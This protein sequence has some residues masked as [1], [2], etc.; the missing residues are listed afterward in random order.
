MTN[1][2]RD[3]DPSFNKLFERLETHSKQ[4]D[5][6][7]EI[8]KGNQS[9]L[10]TLVLNQ[11]RMDK[12]LDDHIDEENATLSVVSN[13]LRDLKGF[14]TILRYIGVVGKWTGIVAGVTGVVWAWDHL[15]QFM[16][17]VH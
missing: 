9:T 2:R 6:H 10:D 8:I 4:L 14:D 1:E 12:K 3:Y 15:V 5:S 13:F 16:T 11:E 7:A 17:K